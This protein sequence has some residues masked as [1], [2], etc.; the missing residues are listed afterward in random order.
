MTQDVSPERVEAAVVALVAAFPGIFAVF[1]KDEL[2]QIVCPILTADAPALL[3]ERIAGLREAREI[4]SIN[5]EFSHGSSKG[6][7]PRGDG[8]FMGSAYVAAIDAR[9]AAL[10]AEME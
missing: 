10:E 6:L 1:G 8:N 2:V 5:E 7:Q 4:V 9:I 3:A